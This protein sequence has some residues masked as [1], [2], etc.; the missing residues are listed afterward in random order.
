[1]AAVLAPKSLG[2]VD[3]MGVHTSL[4]LLYGYAPKGEG[5]CLLLPCNRGKNTT[6]LSSMT[7]SSMRPSMALED[8]TTAAVF[9]AYV[10]RVLALS[11]CPGQ[12]VVMDNI[13][14]HKPKG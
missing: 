7:L 1:M 13:S 2:F 10:E 5:L 9:E 3:E 6:L 8:S 12:V 4:A 14:A 11:L